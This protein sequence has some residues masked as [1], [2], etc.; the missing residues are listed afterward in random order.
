MAKKNNSCSF[1]ICYSAGSLFQH[2]RLPF[3]FLLFHS[4]GIITEFKEGPLGLAP[5]VNS[6]T[7]KIL[8][9]LPMDLDPLSRGCIATESPET[10]AAAYLEKVL[11]RGQPASHPIVTDDQGGR[12]P[13]EADECLADKV[14]FSF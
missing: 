1:L 12:V 9:D 10:L 6:A 14:K 2:S 11:L 5:V 8:L 4:N 3:L 13:A 7:I